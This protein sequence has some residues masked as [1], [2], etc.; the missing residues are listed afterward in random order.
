MKC[1]WLKKG[2]SALLSM[3]MCFTTILS[4]STPVYAATEVEAY[5]VDYPRD[6]DANYSTTSWGHSDAQLM[7]GWSQQ[8]HNYTT[9]HSIGTFNGQVAYCIEPGVGQYSGDTLTGQDESYWENYPASNNVTISPD[10][11]KLLLGRI[12]Q[13]GYQGNV[14]TSWRSQNPEDADKLSH[15]VAT[16]ILVWETV[17]GERDASFHKVDPTAYGATPV[18]D[19]VGS[20]HPLRSQIMSHYDSMV[21][22]VQNHTKVPS[23]CAKSLGSA[24]SYEMKYDGNGYSVTLT[25]TNGVLSNYSFSSSEPGIRFS[26]NGNQ[27]TISADAP[28]T[29]TIQISASKSGG[30]RAG[31]VTW[32]DG[33]KGLNGIQDVITY[34]ETV[35]DPIRAYLL[36][37]MEAVGTMHLVKTSEDGIVSGIPFTITGNGISKNVVTGSDGT[38]DVSDLIAGTYTVTEQSIDRYEPQESQQVTIVGGQTAT[39]TFNNTL[40]RGSLEV[41]KSSEDNFV[42]GVTFHLYGTSLAG[43]AVDEYAVT[44]EN[45]VARFDDVLISGGNQYTV[46]EVDTAIRYVIPDAQTVSIQW[47]QVAERSFHNVLKKFTVTVTKT[48]SETGEPQGDASLA[49]AKYGIY[50]G[51]ELKDVYY[52]DEN[53]QFTSEEYVCDTDWTVQEIEPSEGYLLDTTVHPVGADPA[54]YVIEHNTP[55]TDVT[56]DVIK[57][58]IRLIKHIDAE[59]EDVE[60]VPE[61]PEPTIEPEVSEPALEDEELPAETPSA[62]SLVEETETAPESSDGASL[63]EIES[64]ISATSETAEAFADS[65]AD[66]ETTDITDPSEPGTQETSQTE[67]EPEGSLT[68]ESVATEDIEASGGAGLIEQPEEGAVFEVYLASAGSYDAAKESERDLLVTDADGIAVSKDF[69]YGLY[70]VHQVE[71]MDGQAF[72]PDFTVYISA[73]GQTYSYILNNQTINSFIR[74]EKRD[75]ETG[76]IIP[77]AG[78][79]F[80]IRDLSTG[81]LVSQTVYYPSPVTITTFYTDNSGTLMLPSELPWGPYEL[82]EVAT[83]YGY[84]LDSEP[85]PFTVDGSSDVVTVTKSN[86]PQKGIIHIQKTG[87]IFASVVHEDEL[88]QPVYEVAGL[89]G[90]T[91]TITAKEDIVTPDGTV[92]YTAGEVV[93]II[94]TGPDGVASSKE[95]YLGTYLVTEDE[96]PYGMTLNNEPQPVELVYAG[97]E[98]ELTETS[99][100]FYNERQHV[101]ISLKKFME[102]D[103]LFGIG[104]NGEAANVTFGLYAAETLT[105][106]DG[107]EIPADGLIEIVAVSTDGTAFCQSDLPMGS[108]Y[109]QEL[110]TDSHY[111]LTDE[112]FPVTFEYAGQ[113]IPVVEIA[114]NDGEAISNELKY[115]S[116]SGM[117]TGEDGEALE[118]A[119][120]G[121]FAPGTEEFTEDTALMTAVSVEDGSFRFD[122]VPAGSW[123]LREIQ[124]P[125]GFVLSE[126]Q[127]PVTISEDEQVVEITI[128]NEWIRGNIT[129]TKYDADYPDNKLTGAIFEVYRDSNGNQV[130]DEGDE[131][132]GEMEETSE[133]VYWMEDLIYDGYF[134]KEKVAPEGFILDENAYFVF[135]DTDGETYEVENEAGKGFLNEAM[136]G[137][138]KIVKTTDDGKVEGFAF[139]VQ[140]ANGYDMTFTTDANGEILI[141]NLRISEYVVTEL[142]NEASK[143]YKIA[144]PVTVTLVADETLT[145]HV[146][147]DKITVDVPKTGDDSPLVL[148]LVF[149]LAG[150]AGIAGSAVFYFKKVRRSRKSKTNM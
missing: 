72:A 75:A 18:L 103:E 40:K 66:A 84:V 19:Y 98:V 91:Y 81:E 21:A 43:L 96:S 51:G 92:R 85:V 46:E 138:L 50:K 125:E 121:L 78:V 4:I 145:I 141:E 88:Y 108:F 29:G 67:T 2:L 39:V 35:S 80:Q 99:A 97:Q 118:G 25:D 147:N 150:A 20:S 30:T 38:I 106:A 32:T 71:G 86:M 127:F 6:G 115:G 123:I 69:P 124:Q 24:S 74:V 109:L 113:D 133:G 70:R 17:V 148:W 52:T 77:A 16:Q 94:T 137:S 10:T 7:S 12:M 131:L 110:V 55:S 119:L 62:E 23:F 42:E 112:K 135:V 120:I 90:A 45:G 60:I 13:Y 41:V 122:N 1:K 14:S 64:D 129:L 132:I 128:Q 142:E 73:H 33:N 27:L 117:K 58:N 11:V 31:L 144:D 104:S 111:L 114:A 76:K 22:S 107:S 15:A 149:T 116:V 89:E 63:Q 53:G 5:M 87:E 143:G 126:E 102:T 105:A 48:D 136:K 95:L 79:G 28:V 134:V 34:G 82:I 57:G 101:S 37:E 93:D 83:C 59:D 65:E 56:E 44:D 49:G 139:R 9:V 3:A 36:L 68:P 47:D 130:L 54:L 146:H 61:E 8:G 140:G 100:G 26:Q